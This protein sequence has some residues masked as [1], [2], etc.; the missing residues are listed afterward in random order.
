MIIEE[1][2]GDDGVL[3]CLGVRKGTEFGIDYYSYTVSDQFIGFQSIP[4]GFHYI[5]YGLS[6]DDALSAPRV[7]LY[8]EFNQHK[9]FTILSFNESTEMFD[10][11]DESS[12]TFSEE[13]EK[14]K[15]RQYTSRIAPYPNEHYPQWLKL[16]K[17][18]TKPVINALTPINKFIYS[19]LSVEEDKLIRDHQLKTDPD[20]KFS[21][22]A[23]NS[24]RAFY[25]KIPRKLK[26]K[27]VTPS[28]LT[29]LNIDKSALLEQLLKDSKGDG[30]EEREEM[31][32]GEFQYAFV[33]FLL[34]QCQDAF[35]QWKSICELMCNCDEAMDKRVGLFIRFVNVLNEQLLLIPNDF[36]SDDLSQ[37]N[38]LTK[39]IHSLFLL[40]DDKDARIVSQVEKL[41]SDVNKK[42]D[43]DF[44]QDDEEDT[45]VIVMT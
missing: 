30:D 8:V 37:N 25:R 31:L 15:Q 9:Q 5:F 21:S 24:G 29:K 45:P 17:F 27:G 41:K 36:F 22:K 3:L 35:D 34:G 7:S 16:S 18:I 42:F 11:V 19:T 2:G 1:L 40:S 28:E 4:R 14:Y 32:L 20:H 10:I 13:V 43:W 6:S 33:C 23:D 12:I 26:K 44:E 39:T 38:F